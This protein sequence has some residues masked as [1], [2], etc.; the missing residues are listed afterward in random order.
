MIV[1]AM[2]IF[3]TLLTQCHVPERAVNF[4]VSRMSFKIKQK[5]CANMP[6]GTS[7]QIYVQTKNEINQM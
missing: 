4:E 1:T 3:L 7:E 2:K 5:L 6:K